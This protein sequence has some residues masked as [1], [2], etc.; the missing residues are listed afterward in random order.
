MNTM[1]RVARILNISNKRCLSTNKLPPEIVVPINKE[2]IVCWHPQQD[3]PYEYSL[4]LP[5]KQQMSNSVLCIGEKEIAEVFIHKKKDE[6]I[7]QLAKMTYTT[8]HRWY[9][10]CRD[11]RRRHTDAER[12]YL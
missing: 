5:E 8:K 9:P 12:P 1:L 7:E 10:R 2:M 6:I 11:K 4:P 3:F